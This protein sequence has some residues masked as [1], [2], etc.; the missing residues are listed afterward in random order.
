MRSYNFAL[1]KWGYKYPP[2]KGGRGHIIQSKKHFFLCF[3]F[4]WDLALTWPSESRFLDPN[5]GVPFL[6]V[7]RSQIRST[8]I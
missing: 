5:L 1:S 7:Q 6:Q 3:V 4:S 8:S 2:Q